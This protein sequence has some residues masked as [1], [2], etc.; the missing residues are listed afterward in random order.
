MLIFTN[1]DKHVPRLP[2]LCLTLG[3]FDG[4]HLGHQRIIRRVVEK[5]SRMEG[6]SCV[7]T[8]DPHP[9]ELLD[10]E[11][12]PDLLTSTDKKTQLIKDLGVEALCLVRFTRDFAST[13]AD[14]FIKEFL[15]ETL[16]MKAIVVGY[17]CRFGRNR[18]G[19][20][21][22]LREMSNQ[23]GY[24]VEQVAGVE[25]DGDLRR[26]ARYLGRQYSITGS[27]VEGTKLGREIGFPTANIEP[28]HEAVPPNGIYAVWLDVGG[29]R[30]PGTLN[31]G[32]RPTVTT[33]MKRTVEVHIMD[34]YQDIYNQEVEVTFVEKLRD[35]QKFPSLGALAGQIKKDVEKARNILVEQRDRL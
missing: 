2:S 14:V 28:H 21:H 18:K 29:T 25:A 34:F 7:V 35:E 24:E 6:T 22:L 13:E 20:V 4:I 17:D 1:Q 23:Y 32:Y 16:R 9:R 26:V 5:A 31:I 11:S 19:D 3:I 12:A 8:F 27:I 15:V 10:P 30:K 33:E